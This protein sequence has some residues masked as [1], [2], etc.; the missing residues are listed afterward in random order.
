MRPKTPA[1]ARMLS[2]RDGHFAAGFR[3][4]ILAINTASATIVAG[5]ALRVPRDET[6]FAC[7]KICQRS[8][9][10]AGGDAWEGYMI[11]EALLQAP[12]MRFS[13]L[14]ANTSAYGD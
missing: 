6:A 8:I 4:S 5:G 12:F 2:R 3:M 11:G 1:R 9:A 13:R 14:I 7:V 10:D